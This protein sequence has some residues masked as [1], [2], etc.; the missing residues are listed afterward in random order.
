MKQTRAQLESASS[1]SEHSVRPPVVQLS[2]RARAVVWAA[3][4]AA[5]L[6][7][8]WFF[9]SHGLS[10]IYGDGLVHVEG[11]RRIFDSLS[12]GLAQ[13]GSV[14]L[15]LFHLLAAPLALNGTLWRTGLAG[16]LVSAA[17]FALSAWLLF[18]LSVE[19]NRAL[20]AGV[21]T[22]VC[23]LLSLNLLYAAAAPLTEPL[24]IFWTVLVIFVLFRFEQSGKTAT[25]AWAGVAAFFGTLTRYDGWYLLPF[26]ALF[27]LLCRRRGWIERAGQALLLCLIAAFGPLLW[28]LHN[29]R[30]Y[31]NALQFYD[32]PYSARAIYAHQLATT[33]FR[34]PTDGSLWLSVHYYAAD[35]KLVF[36]A[37]PLELAALGFLAWMLTGRLRGRRAA[38]LLFLVPLL[39]YTHSLAYGSVPLYVPALFPHT[40]YNLRY[41]LEMAPAV[42]LF[43]GFLMAP[44]LG[45]RRRHVVLGVICGLLVF[46][47]VLMG[48]HGARRLP[49]VREGLL[50][51][52]CKTP[53]ALMV[54]HFFR[55]RYDGQ[56]ILLS[57]GEWP[58]L[59]PALGIPYRKT[60]SNANR[61]YW[62][63]LRFGAARFAGWIIRKR[64]DS[65]D[66]LMRAFPKAFERFQLVS[67]KTLPHGESVLIYQRRAAEPQA[68]TLSF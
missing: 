64:G 56:P 32:G 49:L 9:E 47:A 37:W 29:A 6:G 65:V 21:V 20:A 1:A 46:Q 7:G 63:Q 50:N 27:V 18:R 39:F 66:G 22:L 51:T 8:L 34:Y 68:N 36:G 41:G 30:R 23:F 3:I 25:V 59:M 60:I 2:A 19:M 42:A 12:P 38:A 58:C 57:S 55:Q 48:W 67:E 45:Q 24:A 11:A 54:T 61:T 10:N 4:I 16:S 40:Y 31:H 62:R 17:A 28:L 26:A 43:P 35:L 14:W 53:A 15:P 44:G 13:I 33:A 52:P 5:D